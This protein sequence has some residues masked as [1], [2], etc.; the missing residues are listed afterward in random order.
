ML[1]DYEIVS[2]DTKQV[3]I[4]I[5]DTQGNVSTVLGGQVSIARDIIV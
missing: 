1:Q 2:G 4:E 3:E 5:V